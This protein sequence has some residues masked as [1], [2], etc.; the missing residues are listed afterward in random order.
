[1]VIQV[2]A[3]TSNTEEL[4][5]EDLHDPDIHAEELMVLNCG[6]EKTLES[7]LKC[8]EI[9]PVPLKK[10]VLNIHWKD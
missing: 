8:K 9:H 4:Y 7:P 5:K 3:L 10:S 2:Y 6:V 1:M